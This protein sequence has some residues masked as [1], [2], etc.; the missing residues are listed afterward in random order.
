[1]TQ[2]KGILTEMYWCRSYL[3]IDPKKNIPIDWSKKSFPIDWPKK[4][5]VSIDPKKSLQAQV[6]YANM[7]SSD[8]KKKLPVPLLLREYGTPTLA[9]TN[10]PKL[11]P[12][13]FW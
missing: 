3:S 8:P 2:K 13:Q 11:W 12:L 4:K 9:P 5:F 6:C 10:R 7:P 1:L